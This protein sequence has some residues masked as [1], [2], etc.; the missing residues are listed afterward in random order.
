MCRL[1]MRSE[2]LTAGEQ[3]QALCGSSG[4]AGGA[5]SEEAQPKGTRSLQESATCTRSHLQR[6][7]GRAGPPGPGA[8]PL[9]EPWPRKGCQPWARVL[10]PVPT[11]WQQPPAAT[12]PRSSA[13][14]SAP[15]R[16]PPERS[17]RGRSESGGTEEKKSQHPSCFRGSWQ[18]WS[19]QGPPSLAPATRQ[20][21]K[22][23]FPF[24]PS[25]STRRPE[26]GAQKQHS[27]ST[28]A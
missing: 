28:S 21:G 6:R 25:S 27:A 15:P 19:H 22:A 23:Q 4:A 1:Q 3:L 7:R 10:P 16:V 9:G 14:G 11:R 13:W 5:V 12:R 24:P 18:Q 20:M 26:E 8:E 2:E 17:A